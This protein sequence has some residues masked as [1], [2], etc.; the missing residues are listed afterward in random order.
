MALTDTQKAEVRRYLGYADQSQGYYSV[1]EGAMAVLSAGGEVQVTALLTD[2][3]AI[4]AALRNPW[5]I[6]KV[7]RA[8]EV[9]LWVSDGLI[10]LRQEGNRLVNQLANMFG[11]PVLS[12]AFSPGGGPGLAG[13]G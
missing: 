5:T 4:E 3:A 2:L 7:K 12:S 13:R 1:L 11:V 8:E 9:Q 6:Q 10:A